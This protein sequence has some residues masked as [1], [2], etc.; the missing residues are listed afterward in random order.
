MNNLYIVTIRVKHDMKHN[1]REKITGACPQLW[2]R[3]CTDQ[4][5]EHHSFIIWGSSIEQ[6]QE[7]YKHLRVTRIED[8]RFMDGSEIKESHVLK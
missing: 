7:R 5:G 2:G 1:P 3:I 6:V 8:A 4:T